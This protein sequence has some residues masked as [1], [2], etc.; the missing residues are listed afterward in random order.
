MRICRASRRRSWAPAPVLPTRPR[1]SYEKRLSSSF[2]AMTMVYSVVETLRRLAPPG[3]D[4]QLGEQLVADRA[5][6]HHD[7][8]EP[9]PPPERLARAGLLRH[10]RVDL[11]LGHHHPDVLGV[12][13]RREDLPP[14]AERGHPV[15]VLLGRL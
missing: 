11:P 6:F 2:F 8:R 15:V 7:A 5:Q 3:V 13:H 9:R 4:E 12:G 10:R 1:I 14:H